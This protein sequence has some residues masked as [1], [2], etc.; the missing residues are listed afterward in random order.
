[1]KLNKLTLRKINQMLHCIFFPVRYVG[2]E[3]LPLNEINGNGNAMN[4]Q[5]S[6]A[7]LMFIMADPGTALE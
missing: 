1:M 3:H 5:R 2:G 4:L 6:I 7:E